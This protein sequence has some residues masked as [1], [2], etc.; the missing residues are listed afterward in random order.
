M[1]TSLPRTSSEASV[2]H[3]RTEREER[4]GGG[5]CVMLKVIETDVGRREVFDNVNTSRSF[6]VLR[7]PLWLGQDLKIRLHLS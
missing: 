1:E 6:D 3:G 2:V 7:A 4:M 5:V